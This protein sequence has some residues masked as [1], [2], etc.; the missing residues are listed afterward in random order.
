VSPAEVAGGW[1]RLI[2]RHPE[3]PPAK[4]RDVL[5]MLAMGDLGEQDKKRDEDK[6]PCFRHVSIAALADLC[7]SSERTVKRAV[8]WAAARGLLKSRRG[9]GLRN[10]GSVPTQWQLVTG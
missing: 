3:R 4:Q 7:K 8:A 2:F 10:G 9:H 1:L 6:E 5:T